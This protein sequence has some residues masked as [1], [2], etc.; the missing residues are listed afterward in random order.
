[1]SEPAGGI[2]RV[3]ELA[4]RLPGVGVERARAIGERVAHLVA[5]GLAANAGLTDLGAVELKVQLHPWEVTPERL[6]DAVT[7]AIEG[8]AR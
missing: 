7:R 6:A 3:Q 1:M 5:E 4:L 2:V 8:H